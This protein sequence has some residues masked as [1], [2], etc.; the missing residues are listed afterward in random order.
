[1]KSQS[2]ILFFLI[3]FSC[4]A[5][6]SKSVCANR[7][8]IDI[9]NNDWGLYRDYDA[10]W[11]DDNIYMP[12]VNISE[13]PYNPPTCGWDALHDRTEKTVHLPATVEE[14]F[15]G[16]NGNNESVAGDW[17]GVSW[18][19]TTV[20]ADPE[21]IGKCIFIDFESVH[22][23]AE[24]FVNSKLTGY[25]VIGHTPFSV[26]IT[27]VFRPG[28][29][30]EIAVRITDPLGNFNW[31]DRPV[32]KWGKHDVPPC[33]A[34][35]GITGRVFLRAVDPVY[36]DDIYVKNK[37][38]IKE[39]DVVLNM[40]N[41]TGKSTSGGFLVK[42]Y[43]WKNPEGVIWEKSFKRDIDFSENEINFTVKAPHT[44]IWDI[45]NPFLYIA[46]VKFT[47]NDGKITDIMTKRFGFR[48]FDIGEKNGDKR[49][50]LNGK[51]IILRGGMSW[52]FWPVNGVYPTREMAERDVAIAKKLGLNYMNFHRAI[53]QPLAIEVSDEM[54]FLIYEEPG[55][56]SCENAD[57]NQTLWREWRKEK[58][59]RMVKRDRSNP[60]LIIY[61]L[62]NR[63]PNDLEDEDIQNMTMVHEMDPTRIITYISGFWKLPPKKYPTK[64]FFKP[65]DF[66]EY[67]SGWFDMHNHTGT[68]GYTDGFYNNPNDFLRYTDNTDEIV[69]WGEDGGLYSP[70][71][72]QLIKE[73]YDKRDDSYGWQGL[74]F[75]EWYNAF[76]EFLDRNSF[77]KSFHDVDVLTTS[78]GNTT[79]YY[80][81]RIIENIRAGNV[82]DCYTVNGWAAPHVGN[83][84]QI[85]DLYRN[86]C[87]DSEIL[88]R[89]N[90]PLYVAVKLRDK[91]VPQGSMVTADFYIIN[92]S[93]LE[94]SHNLTVTLENE[95]GNKG[96]EKTFK[97]A[98]KGGEEYGQLLAEN[99]KIK[100]GELAGYYTVM[101]TLHD[102]KGNIKAEGSDDVF[103]VDIFNGELCTNGALVDTSGTINKALE[104]NWGFSLPQFTDEIIDPDYIII[105]QNNY[106]NANQIAQLMEC[107]ANGATAVVLEQTD[108]FAE[109]LTSDTIKAADYRGRYSIGKGNF[110][111]G[112]HELL[113]GLPQ[114]QAFNWE[115]QI[116]YSG[117]NYALKL[118]DVETIVAAVS[119]N[120]KEV[121]TALCSIPFGRGRII[122]STLNIIPYLNTDTPQS[123]IAKRLFKNFLTTKNTQAK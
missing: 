108:T 66:T 85:V 10:N 123:V 41:L 73:F 7:T 13:L 46:E 100:L 75:I 24:V 82:T 59:I 116:F 114:A 92:E 99:V 95:K 91:V 117:R 112:E 60:S 102:S 14:Y 52:G 69:F 96:F 84:A 70:P 87:G 40:K 104:K 37:P 77:R 97:V 72:L 17:R 26:D 81:G 25:D 105:G 79:L 42:I 27:N 94:G 45:D 38:S 90:R 74:R 21:L 32:M 62:Q 29:K 64:L 50:Y 58:L 107:V 3:I 20:D 12:P 31:N 19:V 111:A 115:Y 122:L 56:Y 83:Q 47:S 43:P 118:Y 110:I 103:S 113:S 93:G 16:D 6:F 63:T 30:N 15:W 88:A 2:N 9:S 89:Y 48:W 119:D 18:W 65:N 106:G 57:K 23:R 39:V 28:E 68:S 109:F 11:I 76:D 34:F 54:G 5:F 80:H 86:S 55:G 22:L 53:G 78:I 36:I 33:H 4:T 44:K 61:N 51:R 101:A 35:G 8:V 98:I 120:K 1:M 49:L 67:Y 121:G 71:R